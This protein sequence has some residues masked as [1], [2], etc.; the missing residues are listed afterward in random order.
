[1]AHYMNYNLPQLGA[2]R[3]ASLKR[4]GEKAEVIER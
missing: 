3:I 4:V 2:I 1:M